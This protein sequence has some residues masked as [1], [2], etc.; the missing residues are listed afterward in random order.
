METIGFGRRVASAIGRFL[1]DSSVAWAFGVVMPPIMLLA[2]PV[3]FQGSSV[4]GRALLGQ[5]RT[6]CYLG[7]ALAMLAMVMVLKANRGKAFVAGVMAAAAVFG[8]ALGLAILPFSLI[9]IV[10]MGLG[11]LGLSP[12]LSAAVFAWW[13]RRSLHESGAR[14]RLLQAAGGAV[15]FVGLIVGT[16]VTTN[17]LLQSSINDIASSRLRKSRAA[18]DRLARWQLFVDMDAFIAAWEQHPDPEAKQRLADAYKVITG[19]DLEQRASRLRD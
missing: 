9:G 12:F 10:V 5:Y 11:L 17:R 14:H 1:D 4:V 8:S 13:S 3:V 2:D 18:T 7:I 6:A 16:Q 15:L 19:E